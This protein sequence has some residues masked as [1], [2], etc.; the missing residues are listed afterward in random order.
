VTLVAAKSGYI[1]DV[2]SPFCSHFFT[3]LKLFF[4]RTVSLLQSGNTQLRS[5]GRREDPRDQANLD[6]IQIEK[7]PIDRS[8]VI[9]RKEKP[10]D[11]NKEQFSLAKERKLYYVFFTKRNNINIA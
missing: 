8:T 3:K 7:T 4:E 9:V 11:K 2:Y 5:L 6:S 1:A 10:L